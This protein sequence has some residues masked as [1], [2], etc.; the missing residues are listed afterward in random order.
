[1]TKRTIGERAATAREDFANDCALTMI[2]FSIIDL[3]DSM[4]EAM[5]L[6]NDRQKWAEDTARRITQ[7]TPVRHPDEDEIAEFTTD[8]YRAGPRIVVKLEFAAGAYAWAS[9][10]I[11]N[12]EAGV[13]IDYAPFKGAEDR[14]VIRFFVGEQ[15][16]NPDH[17]GKRVLTVRDLDHNGELVPVENEL[18]WTH[19][20]IFIV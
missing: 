18:P 11:Y 10:A 5:V 16:N 14:D 15:N 8:A 9:N 13:R 4:E 2:V 6:W 20:R 7:M 17:P 1:M 12:G 3:L 19:P